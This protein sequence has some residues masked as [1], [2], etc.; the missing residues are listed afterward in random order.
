MNS[1]KTIAQ[2]PEYVS[3]RAA[4]FTARRAW[5]NA[6][7]DHVAHTLLFTPQV[8]RRL[9]RSERRSD[10]ATEVQQGVRQP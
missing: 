8:A 7:C 6:G 4:E 1:V 9:A 10:G 5:T 2:T 3:G